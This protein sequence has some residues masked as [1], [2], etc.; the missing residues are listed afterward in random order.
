MI[1]LAP[2]EISIYNYLMKKDIHESRDIR[3]IEL[4]GQVGD[5]ARV[6][7]GAINLFDER[8]G[9]FFGI[10]NTDGRCLDII[11]QFGRLSAGELANN[12]GLTT[13]AVTAVAD[14]LEAAGY[15]LRVRDPLDRRKI[16]IQPTEHTLKLIEII[17]GVYDL[18]GP[19]MMRHFTDT[20]LEGIL[21]FLRMGTRV[22][23]ELAESL[24]EHAKPG[25]TPSL[26][27]EQAR[28]FRRAVEALTPSLQAEL[29]K[30]L[31]GRDE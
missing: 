27:I 10:N 9:E 30:I 22:N 13:G 29:D 1:A 11:S 4:L 20:Q 8:V 24:R 25:G 5:L 18:L 2:V 16:W 12:A 7:Q 21:A 28:Q 26:Q 19:V 3:R 14:R 23:Q 17:F 15:V 6:N 31:P